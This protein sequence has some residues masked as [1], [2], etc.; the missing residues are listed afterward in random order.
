MEMAHNMMIAKHFPNEYWDEAVATIVYIM[1]QYP[2]KSVKNKIPEESWTVMNHSV[3]HLNFFGFVAYA[4][5]PDE[6][7]NKLDKKDLCWLF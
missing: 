7:R 1:N 2:K 3:S 4:H 5:V 6:L